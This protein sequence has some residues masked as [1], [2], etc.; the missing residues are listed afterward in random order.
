MGAMRALPREGQ[1]HV[2]IGGQVVGSDPRDP[3][4]V[5]AGPDDAHHGV[6]IDAIQ[7]EDRER[8]RVSQDAR[9]APVRMAELGAEIGR[10]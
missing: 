10:A 8:A 7:R 4:P 2:R 9:A 3:A 6:V 5:H 1:A